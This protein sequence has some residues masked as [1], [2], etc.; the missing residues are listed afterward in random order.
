MSSSS[1][2]TGP[3]RMPGPTASSQRSRSGGS[4][5]SGRARAAACSQRSANTAYPSASARD[6]SRSS[7]AWVRSRED[8]VTTLRPSG[9]GANR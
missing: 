7:W 9:N 8:H 2:A 1:A 3:S 4:D 6:Q 5:M